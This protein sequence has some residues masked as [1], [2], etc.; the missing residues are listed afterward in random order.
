MKLSDE[1]GELFLQALLVFSGNCSEM[2]NFAF[3][4][5]NSN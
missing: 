3:Q 2:M 4:M 1:E 5:M